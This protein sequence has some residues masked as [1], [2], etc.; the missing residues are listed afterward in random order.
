MSS[1]YNQKLELSYLH[2]DDE[3]FLIATND[4]GFM[5]IIFIENLH[6]KERIFPTN[7]QNT[8]Y[9]EDQTA[10]TLVDIIKGA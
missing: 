10:K 4:D 2:V 6:T 3:I 8:K 5:E 1:L 9:A 7:E